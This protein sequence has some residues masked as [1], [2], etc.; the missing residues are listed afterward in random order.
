M[1]A[2]S[3]SCFV[4]LIIFTVDDLYNSTAFVAAS[5]PHLGYWMPDYEWSSPSGAQ[6]FV[7]GTSVL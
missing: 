3:V 7:K 6:Y 2:Q 5:A 1:D 4:P